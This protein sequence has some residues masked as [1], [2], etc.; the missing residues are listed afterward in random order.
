MSSSDNYGLPKS[1]GTSFPLE[2]DVP[3]LDRG[4]GNHTSLP[5]PPLIILPDPKAQRLEKF[6]ITQSLLASKQ[7]DGKSICTH[8][9]DMKLH[10]NRLGML[11]VVFPRNLAIDLV[12]QSLHESYSEF[13]KEYYVTD[14]DITLID[15]TY[16]LI[17]AESAMI[18]RNGQAN[19]I[20]RSTSQTN[21]D[22]P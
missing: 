10:I 19:L 5:P 11:G 4:S 17:V 21:M 18:W 20:G 12:L 9:L 13:V 15:L 7:K 22:I 2:D 6:K 1:F 16:L 14:H 3:R 8:V